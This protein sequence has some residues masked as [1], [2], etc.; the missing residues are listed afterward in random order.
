[1]RLDMHAYVI[2]RLTESRGR[3]PEIAK[4][5]DVSLRT[6]QKIARREITDPGVSHIQ[7]LYDHFSGPERGLKQ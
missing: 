6:M 1:M 7:K 5:A 4:A 3:W 2:Q